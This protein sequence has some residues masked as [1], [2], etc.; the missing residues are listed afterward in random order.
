[1]EH[2]NT[3][4]HF[5]THDKIHTI[6]TIAMERA[7]FY[8]VFDTPGHIILCKHTHLYRVKIVQAC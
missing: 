7:Q 5:L 3:R 6:N 4:S 8:D 2:S 1:M